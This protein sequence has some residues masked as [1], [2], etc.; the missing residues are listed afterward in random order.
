MESAWEPHGDAALGERLFER[1]GGGDTEVEDAGGESGV[2]LACAE[3]FGEV[4]DG[5]CAAR[6]DDRDADGRTDGGGE[7]AVESGAGAVGVH[8]GEKDFAC[9]SGLGFLRP[10]DGG[11]AGVFAT[12][13]GEDAGFLN[14]IFGFGISTG[15]DGYDD[16]LRAEVCA[17]LADERGVAECGGVDADFVCSSFEDCCC[18]FGGADAAAYGEGDEEL[19]RGAADGI[20]EC[21]AALVGGGD[22]EEDDF[23]GAFLGV[24]CG[25]RG[26]V[27]GVDEVDELDAFDYATVADV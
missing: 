24:A 2:G 6:S 10:L 9:A 15:V 1:A 11:A 5:A 19:L 21:G 20:E 7:L 26:W 22:I 17:D 27:A 13:V 16:G 12:S 4:G 25:E 8:G 23:V 14:W 3:D 18:V